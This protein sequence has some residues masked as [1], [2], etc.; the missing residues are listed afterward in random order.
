MYNAKTYQEKLVKLDIIIIKPKKQEL[1]M[2]TINIKVDSEVA[3]LYQ[4]VTPAK[5]QEIEQVLN[6]CLKQIIQNRSLDEII[7]DMQQQ[8]LKNGLTEEI[9]H[10]IIKND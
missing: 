10:N 4:E 9:L 3:K 5:R 2:E 6:N 1:N 7:L 8:T